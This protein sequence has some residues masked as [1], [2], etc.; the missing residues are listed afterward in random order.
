MHFAYQK[1]FATSVDASLDIMEVGKHALP[2]LNFEA[3]R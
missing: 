2:I 3:E 1:I